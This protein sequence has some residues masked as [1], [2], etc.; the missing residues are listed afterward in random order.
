MPSSSARPPKPL[1]ERG[2]GSPLWLRA[3]WL[4]LAAAFV[5]L[6][7]FEA[8]AR[9][10]P[11][12]HDRYVLDV[13]ELQALDARLDGEV[14]QSK[15]ALVAHYDAIV[16][17][18]A[19]IDAVHARLRVT[20]AYLGKDELREIE[21]LVESS[22][23]TA[24]DKGDLV[25]VFKSENAVLRNSERFFP[26]AAEE[27][28][29]ALSRAGE[30]GPARAV[31]ELLV[32]TLRVAEL[33]TSQVLR[34]RCEEAMETVLLAPVPVAFD[35]DVEVVLRHAR[36]I[37]DRGQNVAIVTGL[38]LASPTSRRI[39]ELD[40]AY[41]R[42]F[43]RAIRAGEKRRY[44]LFGVALLA[45]SAF[46][47]EIILRLRR[48]SALV[49]AANERLEEVNRALARENE[50]ERELRDLKSR[51]V[52]MASHE[53]RTPLA[54]VLS[55]TELLEAYGE[56][57]SPAKKA[58]H[59]ARIKNAIAGVG[60]LLDG[61]LVIGRAEGGKLECNAAPLDFARWGRNL[62]ET[63]ELT[64]TPKHTIS[65]RIE[66]GGDVWADEKL[67][68]H[69]LTNLLSNAVK[70]SP[71]GCTVR[72]E[73]GREGETLRLSVADEGIGIPLPDQKNLFE[74]FHR[75]KNVGTIRGTGLGLAIV[76]RAVDAHGGT[77]TCA[78]EPGKGTKFE[79]A[80]PCEQREQ[81]E[82]DDDDRAGESEP[83]S[84]EGSRD[85]AE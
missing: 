62:I 50:R 22:R 65:A 41:G 5:V 78:S 29:D 55:S 66:D 82:E 39:V 30:D 75:G 36:A 46:G 19:A 42:A 47:A 58:D 7:V 53:F 3:A 13:G 21:E 37:L 56:R 77:I 34:A 67:L 61:I 63:F 15:Q 79:V 70:Y 26:I 51:F 72:V 24:R 2:R 12:A 81:P 60:E 40:A 11:I 43:E 52:S 6:A 18:R 48:S 64:L 9:I 57:W 80:L 83:P 8:R 35:R 44:G 27:L 20:P 45:L 23:Q 59:F 25:E 73:I 33:P 16:R 71:D 31:N 49:R 76:K 28:R 1:P 74:S 84:L 4:S 17:T 14:M 54:V 32:R 38:V 85:G 68:S 10:D 69:I